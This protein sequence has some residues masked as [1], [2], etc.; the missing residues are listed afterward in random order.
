MSQDRTE[1]LAETNRLAQHIVDEALRRGL[2][3]AD[4]VVAC[5]DASAAVIGSAYFYR[6]L[7]RSAAEVSLDL[8]H[9][10]MVDRLSREWGAYHIP[11]K[12]GN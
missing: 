1:K 2:E 4:L 10:R 9:K 3:P 6:G 11:K 7:E 12:E 8:M 5:A